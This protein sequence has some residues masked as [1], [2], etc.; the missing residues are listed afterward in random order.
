MKS[1]S[2]PSLYLSFQVTLGAFSAYP[3]VDVLQEIFAVFCP[4]CV[5]SRWLKGSDSLA[6]TAA[7]GRFSSSL[8]SRSEEIGPCLLR[9]RERL[10][11]L[12]ARLSVR[13]CLQGCVT[14]WGPYRPSPVSSSERKE[15]L[16]DRTLFGEFPFLVVETRVST[17]RYLLSFSLST[18][19][20][21]SGREFQVQN[22]T[23][24]LHVH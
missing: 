18:Y 1:V 11:I 15:G 17:L 23:P 20:A 22:D 7:A 13:L 4:I 10:D 21:L 6:V 5:L 24:P 19:Q 2:S 16:Q 8:S 9:G 12:S 14:S 3:L